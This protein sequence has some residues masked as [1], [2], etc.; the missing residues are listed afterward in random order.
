MKAK[1]SMQPGTIVTL[2]GTG[3]PGFAGDGGPANAAAL[4]EPK[5][6]AVDAAGNLYIADAENHVIRRVDAASGRI[7]TIAG[8]PHD[9]AISRP[10]SHDGPEDDDPLNAS[11]GTP[12]RYV[13]LS[14]LSGTV[15]FV[16]GQAETQYAGDGGP[17]TEAQ[18]QF[19]SAV[20]LD[21]SGNLYIADTMNHRVRRV[22]ARTGVISTIAGNGQ[23]RYAGDGGPAV[24]AA[25]NEP[26]ALIVHQGFLYIADQ[27]NHRVRRVDLSSG[28]IITIAGTGQSGYAGDGGAG[29]EAAL[30]GPSGLSLGS[31]ALYIAD[32]FNGRIRVLHLA[33]GIIDTAVGD[34]S[35]YRYPGVSGEP[36]LSLSRPY[37]VAVDREGHLLITDSDNHLIR[38]WDRQRR[39]VY[40]VAG[41]GTAGY[42][43]DG[44]PAAESALSYPFGV[45]AGPHG[46][47]YVA[48]T[49]NHRIR[50]IAGL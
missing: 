38:R 39:A 21:D 26:T 32:T 3:E 8:R 4:N 27:S 12:D 16:V 1:L 18:L 20:A 47:I 24:S 2:A 50:M 34:G 28:L 41:N 46:E 29:T 36:A 44:G 7:S 43:G 31:D 33:S 22:E 23:H 5:G 11:S 48:D 25:L 17:A 14:D 10:A 9:T 42:A 6:M 49:F 13:Q 19:P 35:E 30:A 37:A 15:R 40:N 45:T